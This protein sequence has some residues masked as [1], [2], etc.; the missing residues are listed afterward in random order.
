MMTKIEKLLLSKQTVFSVGDLAVLWNM[1]ERKKLWESIKYYLR[2]GKLV[3]VHSGTYV[4]NQDYSE[5]ELAVK[6]FSP[7]YISF[8]TALGIHGIN[9][10]NYH[11]VHAM[12]LVSKK[13]E[14]A[15]KT[16]VYHQ[17]QD[18]IF[19]NEVG[20]EKEGNYRLAS[21][22][23]AICDS[24][25]LVPS[26]TFDVLDQVDTDKLLAV[27]TVYQSQAL[28]KRVSRLIKEKNHA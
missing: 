18:H 11:S 12:A 23:R 13:I 5:L 7:A 27:A 8:H 16:F 14:V 24:L 10:Q 28:A 26:L 9:F 2:I 20:V 6:L 3:R 1:S 15:Q 19:F 4:L 21:P 22:E 25:Y 17:L